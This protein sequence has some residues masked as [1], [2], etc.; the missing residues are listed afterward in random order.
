MH[1]IKYLEEVGYGAYSEM[2]LVPLPYTEIQA[3]S[4]ATKLNL[5]SFDVLTIKKLSTA[6]VSQTK[7]RDQDELAPNAKKITLT[8]LDKMLSVVK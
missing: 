2:G 4:N 5:S 8:D 6:Y 1:L 3:Y 7:Q